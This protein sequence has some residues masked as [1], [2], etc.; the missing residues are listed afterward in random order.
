[1]LVVTEMIARAA[2]MRQETRGSHYRL[3]FPERDDLDW[4]KSI[5]VKQ[6][7]GQMHLDTL[8]PD[9]DWQDRAAKVA[10]FRWG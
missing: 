9:P 10:G 2:L 8:V 5:V 7:G 4:L 6:V 1:M 3:D